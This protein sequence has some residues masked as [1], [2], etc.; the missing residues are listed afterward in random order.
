MGASAVT[1]PSSAEGNWMEGKGAPNS[2]AAPDLYVLTHTTSECQTRVL[3]LWLA[4]WVVGG[5]RLILIQLRILTLWPEVKQRSVKRCYGHIQ[6]TLSHSQAAPSGSLGAISTPA[7]PAGVRSHQ[8][9]TIPPA[10]GTPC[11]SGHCQGHTQK[12]LLQSGST[13]RV[14]CQSLFWHRR[15]VSAPGPFSA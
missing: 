6:G 5:L 13:W 8:E 3:P 11:A 7:H 10:W 14:P 12:P 1:S 9:H 2:E 4:V 15:A